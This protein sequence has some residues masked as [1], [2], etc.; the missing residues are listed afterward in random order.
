[1]DVT[2]DD[3]RGLVK[4]REVDSVGVSQRKKGGVGCDTEKLNMSCLRELRVQS[5]GGN[6]KLRCLDHD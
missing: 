1:M 3:A 2:V 5:V 4:K 6:E